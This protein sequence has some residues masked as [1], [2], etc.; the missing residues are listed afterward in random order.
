LDIGYSK[1]ERFYTRF[2]LAQLIWRLLIKQND[3]YVRNYLLS[4]RNW[5]TIMPY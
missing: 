5:T 3:R 2:H 1:L 4:E